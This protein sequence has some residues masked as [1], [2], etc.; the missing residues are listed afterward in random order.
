LSWSILRPVRSRATGKFHRGT[1]RAFRGIVR[2]QARDHF[3]DDIIVEE[4]GEIQSLDRIPLEEP[5]DQLLDI[6]G[7]RVLFRESNTIFAFLDLAEQ[8]HVVR[9]TE[10]RPSHHHLVEHGANR[11]QVSLGIV[12]LVSKNLR[13]HVKWGT[14][15]GLC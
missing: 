6:L 3:G 9:G 5:A 11:P 10:R 14:T 7:S 1:T 12:L 8:F 13:C 4:F 15:Q 2:Y